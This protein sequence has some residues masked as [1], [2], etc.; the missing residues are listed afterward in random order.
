MT[1]EVSGIR[2]DIGDIHSMLNS[3]VLGYNVTHAMS[4][5]A[6]RANPPVAYYNVALP[7]LWWV[8]RSWFRVCRRRTTGYS[9]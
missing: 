5:F 9:P 3:H 6:V 7:S 1:R 4:D 2:K 8:R